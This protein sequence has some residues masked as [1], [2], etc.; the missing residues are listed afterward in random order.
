MAKIK[1]V[2]I[3]FIRCTKNLR[4]SLDPLFLYE[5][6]VCAAVGSTRWVD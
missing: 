1:K 5:I 4:E 3:K 2:K 6:L